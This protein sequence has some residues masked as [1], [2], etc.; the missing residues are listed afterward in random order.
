[1]HDSTDATQTRRLV[2]PEGDRVGTVERIRDGEIYVRP[3]PDL[4]AGYGSWLCG[5]WEDGAPFRLDDA[6]VAGI[7]GDAIVLRERES[8]SPLPRP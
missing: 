7:D 8:D 6:A 3:D 1:M 5:S 4:L 2:T